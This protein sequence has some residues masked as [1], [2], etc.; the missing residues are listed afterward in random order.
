MMTSFLSREA[1]IEA[2]R[3]IR[4]LIN[5]NEYVK[6][7]IC[8]KQSKGRYEYKAIKYVSDHNPRHLSVCRTCIYKESYGSKNYRKKM[9]ERVIEN[10]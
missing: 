9:K 10:E 2:N 5:P 3:P 1:E 6:C 7:Q 4:K 8:T